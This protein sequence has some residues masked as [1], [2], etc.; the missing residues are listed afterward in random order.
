MCGLAGILCSTYSENI[1]EKVSKMTSVLSHR[2]PN[3]K[4][5]W[6]DQNIALGHRRLA[7]LDLSVSGSQPM[8]SECGRYVLVYNGE[9]Y[10]HLNIR[11]KLE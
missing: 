10:N 5:I 9:I 1:F 3:D 6:F 2:G 7:I 11:N 4:G 8:K